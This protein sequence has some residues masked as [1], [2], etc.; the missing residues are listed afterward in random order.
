MSTELLRLRT[1]RVSHQQLPV[2]LQ[3]QVLDFSL[4]CLV[5]IFLIEGYN[6]SCDCLANGVDL[7]HATTTLNFHAN[8]D[9]AEFL[10]ADEQHR[11]HDLGA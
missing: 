7:A 3:H 6:S 8:V 9:L 2:V 11:L 4:G 10:L 5:H 1:A